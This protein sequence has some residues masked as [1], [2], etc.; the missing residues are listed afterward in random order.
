MVVLVWLGSC[1]VRARPR[2]REGVRVVTSMFTPVS[3]C[4]SEGYARCPNFQ[5]QV[6]PMTRPKC[7]SL[8]IADFLSM[9]T[10]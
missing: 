2:P 9:K 7:T 10:Y 3:A 5:T 4:F 6:R 8:Q 1:T